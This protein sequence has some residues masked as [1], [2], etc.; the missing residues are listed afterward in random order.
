MYNKNDNFGIAFETHLKNKINFS[1][2]IMILDTS[3]PSQISFH[4][5]IYKIINNPKTDS[6]NSIN[7][8]TGYSYKLIKFDNKDLNDISCSLGIGISFNE[9]K[10]NIN[11]SVTAGSRESIVETIDRENYYKFNIGILSGDKWFEKRR[12]N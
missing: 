7:L 2:E 8:S 9:Q 11:I 4:N 5:G 1:E 3:Y 10:N 6:W 12:R